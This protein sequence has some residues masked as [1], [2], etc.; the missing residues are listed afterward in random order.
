MTR[1]RLSDMSIHTGEGCE[2]QL[3]YE[4]DLTKDINTQFVDKPY[5]CEICGKCFELQSA[6]GMHM[7]THNRDKQYKCTG[8]F[9]QNSVTQNDS[10]KRHMVIE[11]GDKH[12]R[13][14]T[15]GKL[16]TCESDLTE[17]MLLHNGDKPYN[18]ARLGDK[19]YSC[20]LCR[21]PFDF[22]VLLE[23][24]F[25]FVPEINNIL[26]DTRKT[27]SHRKIVLKPTCI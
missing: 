21:K 6:F 1:L 13:C 17:H 3:A 9:L 7:L 22:K 20:D 5:S 12:H 26:V 4:G 16:L 2:S 25:L 10:L 23:C 19:A 18:D 8:G 27:Q 24:I 15:C 11:F 14:G